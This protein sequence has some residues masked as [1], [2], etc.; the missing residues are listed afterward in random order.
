[1][2]NVFCPAGML[3]GMVGFLVDTICCRFQMGIYKPLK[4][5]QFMSLEM[6]LKKDRSSLFFWFRL[7]CVFYFRRILWIRRQTMKHQDLQKVT[8]KWVLSTLLQPTDSSPSWLHTPDSSERRKYFYK[9]CFQGCVNIFLWFL[10]K[11]WMGVRF[12]CSFTCEG[13]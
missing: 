5:N 4:V 8:Q 6:H 3:H 1:M 7:C 12:S 13:L 10:N 2:F 9:F 11:G